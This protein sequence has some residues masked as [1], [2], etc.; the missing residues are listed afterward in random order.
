M[1]TTMEGWLSNHQLSRIRG[2][3]LLGDA[4]F[5]AGKSAGS[6]HGLSVKRGMVP[7]MMGKKNK[8]EYYLLILQELSTH[9]QTA[10]LVVTLVTLR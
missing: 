1:R 2:E 5:E 7:Y 9:C 6:F 8:F 10:H 4:G 3:H